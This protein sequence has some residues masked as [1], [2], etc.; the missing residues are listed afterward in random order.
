MIASTEP[1]WYVVQ[2]H[3]R[4]E[5]KAA[6]HLT[7][8]AFEV[9]LPRHLKRRRHARRTETVA[10]PLFPRYLFV[11]IDVGAQRWRSIQSTI[12]VARL[13]CQ[14]EHPLP[15]HPRVIDDL[16]RG[17]DARGFVVL[18]ER[19]QFAPGDRVRIVDGAFGAQL[20]LYEGMTGDERVAV[21]LELLGRK[22]RV[23]LDVDLITAA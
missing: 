19:P 12:G 10:A 17:E 14:G 1:R 9:Y 5:H 21:L 22:V 6:A 7:R 18:N 2:T 20:G 11:R 8:Q 23:K 16:K 3:A 13:V 4:G 15:V